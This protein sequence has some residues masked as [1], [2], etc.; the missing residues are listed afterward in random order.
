M[1]ISKSECN[2]RCSLNTP[3]VYA[4]EVRTD[5]RKQRKFDSFENLCACMLSCFSHVRL[6]EKP[7]DSSPPGSTV[8]GIL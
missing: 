4:T 1:P 3:G 6:F 5:V 7:M 8:C 2:F